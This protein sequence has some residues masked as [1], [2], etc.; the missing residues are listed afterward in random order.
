VRVRNGNKRIVTI[1]MV[2]SIRILC[3]WE[4]IGPIIGYLRSDFAAPKDA[5]Y[6]KY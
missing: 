1:L 5:V 3:F 2:V 4:Q 6:I